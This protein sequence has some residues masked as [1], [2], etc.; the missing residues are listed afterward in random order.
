[1]E[2]KTRIWID[3]LS[4]AAAIRAA[5]IMCRRKVSGIYYL[6]SSFAGRLALSSICRF[7]GYS[8][9][10][11]KAEYYLG[12]MNI[13]GRTAGLHYDSVLTDISLKVLASLRENVNYRR[14]SEHV[15][16]EKLDVFLEMKICD[17]LSGMVRL[18][19]VAE[20]RR[21][22]TG[23]VDDVMLIGY[24]PLA[25]Y[26]SKNMAGRV[27]VTCYSSMRWALKMARSAAVDLIRDNFA[28]RRLITTV[29][30][31]DGSPDRIAMHYAQGI[32]TRRRSDIFWFENSGIDPKS[33]VWY[34]DLNKLKDPIAPETCRRIESMGMDWVCLDRRALSR[35]CVLPAAV[36]SPYRAPGA[37]CRP[38]LSANNN[39]DR[40]LISAFR[41]LISQVTMWSAFYRIFNIKMIFDTSVPFAEMVAQNIAIELSGGIRAGVQRSAIKTPRD[42][43]FMRYNP[44]HV[45]FVW[46]SEAS[47]HSGTSDMIKRLVISGYSYDRIMRD[48]SASAA[49]GGDKDAKLAIALFDNAYNRDG[50]F[51]RNMIVRFYK[52]FLVWLLEDNTVTLIVKEK[53]PEYFEQLTELKDLIGRAEKSG[54]FKRLDN[55]FGRLPIDAA[56]LADISVGVGLSSAAM[57]AAI[58]GYKSLHCD[59]PNHKPHP[60]YE[61]GYRKVIFDDIGDMVSAMKRYKEDP[62]AERGLGD[63]SGHIDSV[64]PFRDGK[65]GERIGGYVKDLFVSL[66]SGA[67]GASAFSLADK[68]YRDKWGADKV[69]TMRDRYEKA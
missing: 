62:S 17:E 47:C 50:W 51:S 20:C 34:F 46:G 16:G 53:K 61:W 14:M 15:S 4:F 10:P 11:E 49:A 43:Y 36:A 55:V 21:P 65:A 68:A 2:A 30:S 25:G 28:L 64:D 40:W 44:N 26:L 19:L 12:D 29:K 48:K 31:F 7:F 24:S 6:A 5:G 58:A 13:N 41:S 35:S 52:E 33:V 3:D 32:D 66:T 37:F 54:R 8:G 57:E 59:L 56:C 63:W 23:P 39:E 18:M 27:S 69:I 45:Y 67:A 22:D 9:A 60:Y 1:M 38:D 42:Q